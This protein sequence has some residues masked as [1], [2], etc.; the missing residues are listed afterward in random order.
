VLQAAFG[1]APSDRLEIP[2]KQVA[3]QQSVGFVLG[4]VPFDHLIGRVDIVLGAPDIAPP[5]SPA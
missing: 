2:R 5:R 3:R 4:D 1:P